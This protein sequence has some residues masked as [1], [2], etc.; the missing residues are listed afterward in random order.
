MS[1]KFAFLDSGTGGIPYMQ[2]LKQKC[3][4]SYCLYL[5]DTLNFP[6]GTKT[7]QQII[8]N[9]CSCISLIVQKWNPDAIVI[10]CN[11]I[12]VTALDVIRRRFSQVHIVGTVPAVKLA[13]TVSK[14]HTIGL[15]ATEGTVHHPYITDLK[16]KFASDCNLLLRGDS[17]LVSFVE[18]RFFKS[19]LQECLDAVEPA[20]NFFLSHGCDAIILGCTHFV[21]LRNIFQQAVDGKA[22]IVDSRDGVVRQSLKVVGEKNQSPDCPHDDSGIFSLLA[23]F[24]SEKPLDQSLF[25]TGFSG[26]DLSAKYQDLCCSLQIPWGG[27]LR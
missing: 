2:Y 22:V 21:H 10:A 16:E 17:N 3:P 13:A 27:I 1:F 6:Y 25:V 19:S 8:E 12:S 9:A 7:P 20:C 15:L 4:D 11:T 24:L 26:Q 14:N 18:N 5:A 23:D